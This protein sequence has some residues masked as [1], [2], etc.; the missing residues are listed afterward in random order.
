MLATD[1]G[2][3]YQAPDNVI[4]LLAPDLSRTPIG[5][6][7]ADITGAITSACLVPDMEEARFTTAAGTTLVFNLRY[8]RWTTNTAQPATGS[9]MFG[10]KWH[11]VGPFSSIRREDPTAWKDA[12]TSYQASLEL[13]WMS[14]GQIAGYARTW[15]L[16]LVGSLLGAHTL[17]LTATADF[18]TNTVTRTLVSTAIKAA[19]GYRVEARLPLSMQQRTA[20]KLLIQDN[21]P[22]TAGWAIDALNLQVGVAPGRRPRLPAAHVMG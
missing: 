7:T 16:Q 10:G 17:S 21:S 8:K 13:S 5:D 1:L 18:G 22:N 2:V 19:F 9:C 12:G 20:L 3:F 11:Y 14:L 6:A 15:A 4:W